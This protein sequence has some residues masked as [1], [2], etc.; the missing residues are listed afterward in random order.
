VLA[1]SV[2]DPRVAAA[3]VPAAKVEEGSADVGTLSGSIPRFVVVWAWAVVMSPRKMIALRTV[4]RMA[5]SSSQKLR[6][7]PESVRCRDNAR[8]VK[9][10]NEV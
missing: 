10:G 1:D 3:D 2:A 7:A 4:R 9:Q 6:A 5:F 8:S